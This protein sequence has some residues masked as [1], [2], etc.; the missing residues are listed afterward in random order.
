MN[1]DTRMREISLE[2][3]LGIPPGERIPAGAN[4]PLDIPQ[5][6]DPEDYYVIF[7]NFE[8]GISQD[9]NHP[10]YKE[11]PFTGKTIYCYKSD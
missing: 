5:P 6:N 7:T 1:F 8:K 9:L 4:E 11:N 3:A 2:I 10:F